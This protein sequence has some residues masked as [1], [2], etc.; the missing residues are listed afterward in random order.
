MNK[1][2]SRPTPAT[3]ALLIT[4]IMEAIRY[5]S[6]I[7]MAGSLIL[8]A[9]I[10]RRLEQG[11]ALGILS[12][13]TPYVVGAFTYSC[14]GAVLYG[15]WTVVSA[16]IPDTWIDLAQSQGSREPHKE[17]SLGPG[18]PPGGER[19]SGPGQPH[20][21][22]VEPCP[23]PVQGDPAGPEHCGVPR[24]RRRPAHLAPRALGR[25]DPLRRGSGRGPGI[26]PGAERTR[27][28]RRPEGRLRA[29][30]RRPDRHPRRR[31]ER[32][33]RSLRR[34][35]KRAGGRGPTD[36]FRLRL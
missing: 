5:A 9:E 29:G 21:L 24:Q 36:G 30:P 34:A 32:A 31:R 26:V 14:F 2:P 4:I 17:L 3:L 22:R 6:F 20:P 28:H 13:G 33:I 15:I 12:A 19:R 1:T 11:E 35:G 8:F 16:W 23:S 7:V 18:W 27:R 25:R 10:Y